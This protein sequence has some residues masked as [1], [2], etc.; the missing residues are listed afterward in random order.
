MFVPGI[1]LTPAFTSLAF[2]LA[3]SVFTFLEY[4][5]YFALYP[6]GAPIHVFFNEFIDSKDSGPVILSHFYLLTGSAGGVWLEGSGIKRYSGV[7]AL[8]IGDAL[9]GF[10]CAS[11]QYSFD[12]L[13]LQASILGKR[14]G[15]TRWPG[16]NKTLA[17][18]LAFV[19]SI[20]FSARL[21]VLIG[22]LRTL[23]GRPFLSSN[24]ISSPSGKTS[25]YLL[26]VTLT[27]LLEATSTQNDNLV[28]PIFFWACQSLFEV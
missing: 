5:R 18:T 8:G 23:F 7:L 27:G 21:L 11:I 28:I 20:Y 19:A 9:V 2:S 15:G 6:V 22:L 3:F 10:P 14:L 24:E 4:A 26:C 13:A 1:A 16:T 17:G 25:R 12:R